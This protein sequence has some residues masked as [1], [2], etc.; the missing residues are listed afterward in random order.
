M[1]RISRL[2]QFSV[3]VMQL[4]TEGAP[5]PNCNK[6]QPTQDLDEL[7]PGTARVKKWIDAA[8]HQRCADYPSYED[9][10]SRQGSNP[11]TEGAKHWNNVSDR[12]CKQ[13]C[14]SSV[15]TQESFCPFFFS[16][17]CVILYVFQ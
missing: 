6:N 8:E 11:K 7:I 4:T 13:S 2:L 15:C 5:R 3:H 10:L 16:S 12:D 14:G 17:V 9:R 1:R